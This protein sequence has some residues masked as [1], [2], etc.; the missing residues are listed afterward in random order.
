M[1]GKT[2]NDMVVYARMTGVGENMYRVNSSNN[3]EQ[4]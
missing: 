2:N 4:I 3:M 1:Q